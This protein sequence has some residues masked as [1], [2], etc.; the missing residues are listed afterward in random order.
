MKKQQKTLLFW[1][2]VVLFTLLI[3][4]E[5]GQGQ[6]STKQITYSQFVDAVEQSRV[7]EVT[8]KGQDTIMGKFKETYENGIAFELT[9]NTGDETFKFLRNNGIIPI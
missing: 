6:R 7:S 9:G 4:R 3:M 8:F 1:A 2:V 5:F